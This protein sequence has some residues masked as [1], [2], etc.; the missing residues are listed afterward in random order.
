MMNRKNVVRLVG[1]LVLAGML[2]CGMLTTGGKEAAKPSA[3]AR[4]AAAARPEGGARK[5]RIAKTKAAKGARAE[6]NARPDRKLPPPDARDGMS[7]ADRDLAARIDQALDK[8]SLQEA[9]TCFDLARTSASADVRKS[10]VEA[11][12]WFGESALPELT[13]FLSDA[14]DEVRESALYAWSQAVSELEEDDEKIL[15][16]ESVMGAVSDPEILENVANEYISLDDR[17]VVESLAR[18]IV[19]DLPE[20][21]RRR[22]A[23]TYEDVTGDPWTSVEDAEK[24]LE[25]VCAETV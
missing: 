19:S 14:D 4:Q 18:L 22:A 7:R 5:V 21:V 8:D 23:E 20:S 9:L 6:R 10:M 17:L 1:A 24:W 3:P 15:V 25:E 16:I 12:E 11:L 2:P 13:A